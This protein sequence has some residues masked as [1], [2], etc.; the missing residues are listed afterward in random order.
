M[1]RKGTSPTP[2][3]PPR[4][5]TSRGDR[6]GGEP[7]DRVLRPGAPADLR[8]EEPGPATAGDGGD[9]AGARRGGHRFP[10]GMRHAGEGVHVP[11]VPRAQNPG[12]PGT[13]DPRPP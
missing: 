3:G 4:S 12:L 1:E 5:T 2:S 13:A 9:A 7:G 10:E 11:A 8:G 6:R